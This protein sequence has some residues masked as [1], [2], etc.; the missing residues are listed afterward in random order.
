MIISNSQLTC[1]HHLEWE[2]WEH[3]LSS[4]SNTKIWGPSQARRN[5]SPITGAPPLLTEN[6]IHHSSD[7][8][9]LSKWRMECLCACWLISDYP[10]TNLVIIKL[11]GRCSSLSDGVPSQP[12]SPGDN[13]PGRLVL[14][15]I[16]T[17]HYHISTSISV[18]RLLCRHL[19]LLLILSSPDTSQWLLPHLGRSR[20]LWRWNILFCVGAGYSSVQLELIAILL[21]RYHKWY[22]GSFQMTSQLKHI[23]IQME[24]AVKI[25][26][27]HSW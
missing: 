19:Y 10:V 25:P 24:Q 27:T 2:R 11:T 14:S 13:G 12:H 4:S 15:I 23:Y 5:I 21:R 6:T 16:L 7:H 17:P 26:A 18:P 20:L 1:W 22:L 8:V 9:S 3:F